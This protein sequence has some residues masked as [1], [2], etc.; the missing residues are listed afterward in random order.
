MP[1]SQVWW[2]VRPFHTAPPASI[3]DPV[4]TSPAV[5]LNCVIFVFIGAW[6]RFPDMTNAALLI[7]PGRLAAF[8]FSIL[9][10]RR[11]PPLLLLYKFVPDIHTWQEALFCGWFGPMGVV[12]G[13]HTYLYPSELWALTLSLQGAVFVSTF[14]LTLLPEPQ[15]PPQGQEQILATLLHPVVAFT[16]LGSILFREWNTCCTAISANLSFLYISPRRPFNPRV[17]RVP[18]CQDN[19]HITNKHGSPRRTPSTR[20]DD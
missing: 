5:I 4:S 8:F 2:R 16:I 19:V 13:S 10:I 17:L 7:S 14:A 20:V 1:Y 12:S 18:T 3:D 11:I 9:F 6:I 15:S